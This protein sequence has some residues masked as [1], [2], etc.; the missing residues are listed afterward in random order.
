MTR[1]PE[2]VADSKGSN[3]PG[4]GTV[5]LDASPDYHDHGHVHV[6][7]NDVHDDDND[8]H[9]D[10]N[11]AHHDDNDDNLSRPLFLPCPQSVIPLVALAHSIACHNHDHVDND[12][13]VRDDHDDADDVR[14]D[15]MVVVKKGKPCAP[16]SVLLGSKK[17]PLLKPSK[18]TATTMTNLTHND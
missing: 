3:S 13:D 12:D 17:L 2:P 11:D 14:D 10:D 7:G 5:G 16:I 18:L 9:D 8:V 6:H 15:T 4:I 1:E